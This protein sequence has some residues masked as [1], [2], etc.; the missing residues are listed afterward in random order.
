MRS[1]TWVWIVVSPCCCGGGP[2]VAAAPLTSSW[3]LQGVTSI[4]RVC[5]PTYDPAEVEKA[6]MALH[7]LPFDDGTVPPK[8]LLAGW[9][10]VVKGAEA[11]G[12]TVAIHCVAGTLPS[13][14]PKKP[15]LKRSGPLTAMA[16]AD[17]LARHRSWART[18]DGRHCTSR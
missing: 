1:Q 4:V 6:G 2:A 17:A 7:E 5:E 12:G 18:R 11:V 16:T 9:R 14:R 10:K 3:A 15:T 13:P 8:D